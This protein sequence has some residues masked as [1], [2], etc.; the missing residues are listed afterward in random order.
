MAMLCL[1]LD[2]FKFIND[3][4]GHA[5]GDSLLKMVAAR[6]KG[7]IR[8][9]DTVAR[10]GGDEFVLVLLGLADDGRDVG[11]GA[12][13]PGPPCVIVPQETSWAFMSGASWRASI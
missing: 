3:G 5:V 9:C 13:K 11:R 4:F 10:L 2:G 12:S 8:E 1:D 6:L 7:A